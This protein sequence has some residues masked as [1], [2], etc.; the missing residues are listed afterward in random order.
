MLGR[1]V[2]QWTE[3]S[4]KSGQMSERSVMGAEKVRR[5][6][7]GG[8]NL[9]RV[10]SKHLGGIQR[11]SSRIM[12]WIISEVK[13][14]NVPEINAL[15]QAGNP[16]WVAYTVLFLG[17]LGCG[18]TIF[19]SLMTHRGLTRVVPRLKF[20]FGVVWQR[21]SRERTTNSVPFQFHCG[22]S[23]NYNC[24]KSKFHKLGC[25]TCMMRKQSQKPL[26]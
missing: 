8:A 22:M 11:S 23:A 1:A 17:R 5:G 9:I 6:G 4:P 25:G 13:L 15:T 12:E 26:L 18:S 2:L 21:S 24:L 20:P 14:S 19:H 3:S 16:S 10:C 7:G